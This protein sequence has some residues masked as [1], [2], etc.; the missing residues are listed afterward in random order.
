[1][2]KCVVFSFLE[3]A[4]KFDFLT[5]I[6]MSKLVLSITCSSYGKTCQEMSFERTTF[7]LLPSSIAIVD[8]FFFFFFFFFAWMI[9]CQI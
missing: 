8:F 4:S 6:S 2:N 7:D 9:W 3:K 1:M 5:K